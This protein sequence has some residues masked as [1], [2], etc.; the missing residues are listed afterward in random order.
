[1]ATVKKLNFFLRH[2]K[3][4]DIITISYCPDVSEYYV[5][6]YEVAGIVLKHINLKY[7]KNKLIELKCD[8][9][10]EIEDAMKVK[11]GAPTIT[12]SNDTSKCVYNLTGVSRDMVAK[13]FYSKWN[14]DNITANSYIG[15]YF[16]SNC[17][18]KYLSYFRY[19]TENAEYNSCDLDYRK[20]NMNEK[21]GPTVTKDKLKEF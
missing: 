17:N 21:Y 16:D 2:S 10:K 1:M 8:F 15:E 6:N 14:N 3:K 9:S 7:Y 4:S 11:Y 13:K 12:T 18:K 20:K 5:S 19:Y